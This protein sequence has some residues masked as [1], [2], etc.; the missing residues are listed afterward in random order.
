MNAEFAKNVL[1]A[2]A[3]LLTRRGKWRRSKYEFIAIQ[4]DRWLSLLNS[5]P[6]V[7]TWGR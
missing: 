7:E 2:S 5:S 3:F 6:A 4:D 1:A